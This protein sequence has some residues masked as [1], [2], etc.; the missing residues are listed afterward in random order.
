MDCFYIKELFDFD[1]YLEISI[2]NISLEIEN[3]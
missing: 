2:K 1:F 3:F